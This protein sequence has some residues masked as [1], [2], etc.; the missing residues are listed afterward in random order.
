MKIELLYFAGC[1]S[2]R[3]TLSTLEQVL[4]A[5]KIDAQIEM[6]RIIDEDD[7]RQK[8]F[9]GSPTLRADGEDLF[10]EQTS[11]VFAMQCRVYWTTQGFK[12]TPTFDMLRGALR[13]LRVS[14]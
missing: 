11:G 10:P 4:A 3:D 6:V 13:R 9:V 1:P 12:G 14:Q 7:A 8:Q 5:E 2:Y